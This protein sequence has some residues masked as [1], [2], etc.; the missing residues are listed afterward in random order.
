MLDAIWNLLTLI[1][2]AWA[3]AF[4]IAETFSLMRPKARD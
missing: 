1:F 2:S 3:L 4:F